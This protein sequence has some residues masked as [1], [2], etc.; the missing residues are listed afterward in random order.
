MFLE[1][2]KQNERTVGRK[3]TRHDEDTNGRILNTKQEE[4]VAFRQKLERTFNTPDGKNEDLDQWI[5]ERVLAWHPVYQDLFTTDDDIHITDSK[6]IS[7]NDIKTALD[8]FKEKASGA[9]GIT[10]DYLLRAT[11]QIIQQYA[12][13]F[14][15][16]KAI[17]YFPDAFKTAKIFIVKT[18]AY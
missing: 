7:K 9:T 13:I 10:R 6:T 1:R 17:G 15:A 5:E 2:D 8:S 11:S 18:L 12:E 14:N 16:A 4:V 3:E